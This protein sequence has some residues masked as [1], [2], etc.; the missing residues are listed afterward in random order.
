MGLQP[1]LLECICILIYWKYNKQIKHPRTKQKLLQNWNGNWS[2]CQSSIKMAFDILQG[3]KYSKSKF[4][5]K[6]KLKILYLSVPLLLY[7][8]LLLLSSPC[9]TAFL[10]EIIH[11][12]VN[13][14]IFFTLLLSFIQ[15]FSSCVEDMLT[16]SFKFSSSCNLQWVFT[17]DWD[18][19]FKF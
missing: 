12:L 2:Y 10:S 1:L 5:M 16:N 6:W 18:S 11:V 14:K 7:F 9:Y 17:L 15:Y 13:M 4:Q 3:I 8:S 19:G